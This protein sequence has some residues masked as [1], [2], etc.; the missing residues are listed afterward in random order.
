MA[1]ASKVDIYWA[2]T[3]TFYRDSRPKN[4]ISGIVIAWLH[5]KP[6]ATFSQPSVSVNLLRLKK[7]TTPRVMGLIDSYRRTLE[8]TEI[9]ERL[10]ALENA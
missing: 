7:H 6:L 1:I 5:L 4:S 3:C 10:Q 9:E 8:L 2:N